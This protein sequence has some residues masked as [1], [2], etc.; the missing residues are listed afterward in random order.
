MT[1]EQYEQIGRLYQAALKREPTERAAF[2]AEICAGDEAL[3]REV[4]ALIASHEQAG[5]FIE[6]PPEDVALDWQTGAAAFAGQWR[7]A[8][9]FSRRAIEQAARGDNREVAARYATEQALRSAVLGNCQT[10]KT[11]AAQGLRFGRGRLPLARAALAQA[12]CG[13]APQAQALADELAKR[14]PEDTLSQE[15]WLP[16]IRAAINLQRGDAALG[17]EQLKNVARYEAA[18]EFWPPYL[19]GQAYLKLGRGVEA[20]TEF[21]KILDHR[22]QAPLS[23]VYPLANLG[24][25]RAAALVGDPA[26][27]RR[28]DEDFFAVWKGADP[29]LPILTKAKKEYEQR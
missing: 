8:Q 23:A 9:E 14:F 19:R 24:L 2:L 7:Q 27:S 20:A 21:Q 5:D 6:R 17:I 10:S 22:G 26:K 1:P 18:A 12:L 15:I 25:A 4:A 29:D 3:R 28:A 16:L 11:S 13:A